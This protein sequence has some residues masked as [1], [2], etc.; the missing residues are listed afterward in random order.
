MATWLR[1][2]KKAD[3]VLE[4]DAKKKGCPIP[5]QFKLAF[6]DKKQEVDLSTP[7]SLAN[8]A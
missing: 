2:S 5:K 4:A 1:A 3:K 6:K 7:S 8:P